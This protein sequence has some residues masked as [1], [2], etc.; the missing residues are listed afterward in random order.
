MSRKSL[1]VAIEPKILS[2]ARESIG[3]SIQE[4]AK[5]MSVSENTVNS[6]ELG[7]KK[8]TL[9]QLEKLAKTIY[10]RPLAAFFLSTPPID[11]PLPADYRVLPT[12]KKLPFSAKTRLA[13]R[14]ARRLQTLATELMENLNKGASK[15]GSL[16]LSDNP[17]DAAAKIRQESEISID[18]Q[19]KW[20]NSNEA[21]NAWKRF[22]EDR[23]I[24][25]FQMSLPL[26]D[27]IRGFSLADGK[28]PT[29]VLNIKD[30][31]NGRIFSLFHEYAHLLLNESG[32]CNMGEQDNLPK[33][34]A[35]E[36]FCNH[37]SGSFLVPK[38]DLA[39]HS[40]VKSMK[41]YTKISD[42]ILENIANDF[43]VSKEVILLRMV[44]FGWV[45]KEM[46]KQKHE[47]WEGKRKE[48]PEEARMYKISQPKKC[49]RENGIPF[50]SLVMEA[51]NKG[52]ITYRDISDYLGVRTRHLPK[53]EQLI[54]EKV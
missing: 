44:T 43:K 14:R 53:I 42:E 37:F 16:K 30:S 50:V 33:D 23:R 7:E 22:L 18:K 49:I 20:K 24:L 45:P 35:I 5:R 48:I 1:E 38:N 40:V 31:I 28:I 8:P 19:L 51:H 41:Q 6:W 29:V 25:I 47:E 2:W 39:S 26:E 12:D 34:K 13:I 46:Y 54:S 52:V 17:E 36:K 27:A 3:R 10:K 11:P 4:V 21:F 32:V 15:V 9:L